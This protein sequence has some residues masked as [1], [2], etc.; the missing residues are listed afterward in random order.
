MSNSSA[1]TTAWISLTTLV[2]LVLSIWS[3]IVVSQLI[4]TKDKFDQ[5]IEVLNK[6]NEEW[7]WVNDFGQLQQIHQSVMQ[8]T[9]N[10]TQLV[11]SVHNSS[12]MAPA[13]SWIPIIGYESATLA[14]VIKNADQDVQALNSMILSSK[15]VVEKLHTQGFDT[16]S[17]NNSL[18]SLLT[19]LET[20]DDSLN[21]LIV[22]L[23]DSSKFN[24]SFSLLLQTPQLKISTLSI[25][26]GRTIVLNGSKLASNFNSILIEFLIVF[27]DGS[28]NEEKSQ[29]PLTEDSGF[30]ARILE[31]LKNSHKAIGIH[32]KDFEINRTELENA[33]ANYHS[34][35]S[36]SLNKLTSNLKYFEKGLK[37]LVDVAPIT[38]E[39]IGR[40]GTKNY[41]VLGHSS[42]E[43]RA[44]G[45]FVSSIWLVELEQ[46]K[47]KDITYEDAVSVDD[48]ERLDMYPTA[49]FGLEQHMNAWVW[50]MRDVSWDPDFPT[51][52][53]TAQDMY[54]IGKRNLVDGVIGINQ[55]SLLSL[56]KA[57]GAITVPGTSYPIDHR[58]LL[59]MLEDGTD[60][61]GRAF[62]DLVLQGLME[63]FNSQLSFGEISR[64][65]QSILET[66]EQKET[67]LHFDDPKL[68][69]LIDKYGWGGKINQQK[70]DYLYVIDSNVGWSKVDRN[71][72]RSTS[73][74]IDL[75]NPR[76]PRGTLS[77]EYKNHSGPGSPPCDPQWLNRGS[78]YSQL[79][80]A[81]YW[82]FVRA[83]IPQGSVLLSNTVLPLPEYSVAAEVGHG[84]P[85]SDTS[86]IYSSHQKIVFSGIKSTAA[87]KTDTLNIVYDLPPGLIQMVDK[88]VK[89]SLEMAKQPG[90]RERNVLIEIMVP[91]N[92]RFKSSSEVPAK[93]S[94][95]RLFFEFKLDRDILIDVNF[96]EV[97]DDST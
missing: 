26:N 65:G 43:L 77:L 29:L 8:V 32:I 54:F 33:L 68:Q 97:S 50:L 4:S 6:Q 79:K 83:Y 63:K 93:I 80:N 23:D 1:W 36:P 86:I 95:D 51:T 5:S 60:K 37:F 27:A 2:V 45:G 42:D 56:I 44:T 24:E 76:R 62:M 55:W 78:N 41:L 16:A 35:S 91:R 3:I 34:S 96:K 10:A 88:Q 40:D 89:Y 94:D 31:A 75:Q 69:T 15:P 22:E 85:G 84:T 53:K 72:Q 7:D 70:T 52:A 39:L 90:V 17:D 67:L 57:M 47:L 87:G 64:L 28:N 13:I 74:K 11:Q 61:H 30:I 92:Y 59:P 49:P 12:L 71:I 19:A 58:N 21:K 25:D 18:S 73:Y 48:W 81:C 14:H 38:P 46:G 20:M 82:N 9:E 66:M